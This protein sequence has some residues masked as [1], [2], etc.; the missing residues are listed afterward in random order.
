MRVDPLSLP[1]MNR[2]SPSPWT[3]SAS[4]FPSPADDYREAPLDLHRHLVPH[5][6]ATFFMRVADES[7]SRDGF[8]QHDLL[9][10][11]RSLT[12]QRGDWVI[13]ALDG[14]LCL[15]RLDGNGR[16][17]WLCPADPGRARLPLDD[18]ND[19]RLWG[20]VSHIIHACRHRPS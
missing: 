19:V 14:E 9:I 5:P 4:G 15:Q 2:T 13:A 10:V 11:D 12:A 7:Q 17:I 20:V 18:E 16:R 3:R 8:H 6:S 1:A